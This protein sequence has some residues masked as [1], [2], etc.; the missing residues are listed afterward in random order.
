MFK[1][2]LISEGYSTLTHDNSFAAIKT[3][4]YFNDNPF[5]SPTILFFYRKY[6][7]PYSRSSQ[8]VSLRYTLK[9]KRYFGVHCKFLQVVQKYIELLWGHILPYPKDGLVQPKHILRASERASEQAGS[10]KT[11]SRFLRDIWQTASREQLVLL[12]YDF[13][14]FC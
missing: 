1:L 3:D 4:R 9:R 12:L 13:L 2:T 7:F 11:T 14:F 10:E 8:I 5:K 6:L